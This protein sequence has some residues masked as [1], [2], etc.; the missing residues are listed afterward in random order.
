MFECLSVGCLIVCVFLVLWVD[1]CFLI[2]FGC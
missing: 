1:F 2:C